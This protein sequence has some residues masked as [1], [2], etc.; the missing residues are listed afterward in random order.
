MMKPANLFYAA[1]AVA[2]VVAALSGCQRKQ[3]P[4]PAEQAGRKLDQ[5][6]QKAGVELTQAAKETNAKLAEAAKETSAKLNE[7]TEEAGRKIEK[8][9]E[10]IQASAREARN[11]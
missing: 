6:T 7:A 10:K 3:E 4:G 2:I 1:L 8:A 11:K 9:G 5:V